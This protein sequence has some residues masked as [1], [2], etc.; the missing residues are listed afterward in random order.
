MQI[1]SCQLYQGSKTVVCDN[2]TDLQQSNYPITAQKFNNLLLKVVELS[3][4]QRAMIHTIDMY[5]KGL[6]ITVID[7]SYYFIIIVVIQTWTTISRAT[8]EIYMTQPVIH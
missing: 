5:I 7:I 2:Y 3:I 8:F 4:S 6:H 1:K